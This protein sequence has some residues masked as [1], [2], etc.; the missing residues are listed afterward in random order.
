M[1]SDNFYESY[2]LKKGSFQQTHSLAMYKAL[3]RIMHRNE[4][5]I[6]SV[7]LNKQIS[8]YLEETDIH[9]IC[10]GKR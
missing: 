2:F 10:D 1:K 9:I 8:M 3:Y 6:L 5:H 7:Y 4:I